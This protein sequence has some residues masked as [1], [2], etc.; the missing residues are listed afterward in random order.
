MSKPFT[1]WFDSTNVP[2]NQHLD[3]QKSQKVCFSPLKTIF[4]YIEEK[5]SRK[6]KLLIQPF[7]LILLFIFATV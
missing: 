1:A 2:K 3:S 5:S 6:I 7:I 4:P